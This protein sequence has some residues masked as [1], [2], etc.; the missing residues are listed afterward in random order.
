MPGWVRTG[1]GCAALGWA[2]YATPH[3][4]A[5]P[6]IPRT[7]ADYPA[8]RGPIPRPG[9]SPPTPLHTATHTS[10]L[11]PSDLTW[12]TVMTFS[13]SFG[14]VAV[15]AVCANDL[16]LAH[17]LF[18]LPPPEMSIY[19]IGSCLTELDLHILDSVNARRQPRVRN[20]LGA[21][22]A[23]ISLTLARK[24]FRQLLVS[25]VCTFENCLTPPARPG[26]HFQ[27]LPLLARY[28]L[29]RL[30]METC[31]SSCLA[32]LCLPL[33]GVVFPILGR[34]VGVTLISRVSRPR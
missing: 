33:P 10:L 11:L 8:S 24:L 23:C 13:I 9:L 29:R 14:L 15:L 31:G 34:H 7:R 30:Q 32:D 2:G 25:C 27:I 18:M 5:R 28:C 19:A 12:L 3:P 1:L 21:L 17:T 22:P 16:G 20:S 4:P 6:L 26:S